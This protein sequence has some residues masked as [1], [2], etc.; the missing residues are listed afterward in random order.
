MELR[1][2]LPNE[3]ESGPATKIQDKQAPDRRVRRM[4]KPMFSPPNLKLAALVLLVILVG[5][6]VT[7][8]RGSKAN[9]RTEETAATANAPAAVEVTTA[10]AVKRDLP[11]F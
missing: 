1:Q 2:T 9:V 7:S 6:F 8:C 3:M 11:R 4:S 10:A 5:V